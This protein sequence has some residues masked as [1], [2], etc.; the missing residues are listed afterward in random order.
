MRAWHL[1]KGEPADL[2][3]YRYPGREAPDLG[4][5]SRAPRCECDRCTDFDTVKETRI[6]TTFSDYETIHPKEN[7]ELS[8]HQYLVC[9][10][11]MFGFV[12]KDRTYGIFAFIF[13][14]RRA[15]ILTYVGRSSRDQQ[16]RKT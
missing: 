14:T 10:S 7:E 9:M 2:N 4:K 11:H 6:S 1:T 15:S 8:E 13:L 12:L 16:S 5:R 3:L